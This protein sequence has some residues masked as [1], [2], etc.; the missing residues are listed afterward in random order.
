MPCLLSSCIGLVGREG[1]GVKGCWIV[2]KMRNGQVI[3]ILIPGTILM[4]VLFRYCILKATFSH[5]FKKKSIQ[6]FNL[7]WR[8]ETAY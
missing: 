8:R 5:L 3:C 2:Q 1:E 7:D 6:Y 4:N